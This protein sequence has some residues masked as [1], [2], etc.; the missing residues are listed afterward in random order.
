MPS[1][2]TRATDLEL[3]DDPAITDG[4]L[5]VALDELRL[6]GRFLGGTSVSLDALEPVLPPATPTRVLDLGTGGADF[7]A[8][9]VRW[10]APHNRDV[11]VEGVD[12]NP[13]T[14]ALADAWLDQALSPPIAP[15]SPSRRA[16]R[17]RCRSAISSSTWR[18]R[19]SFS[20]TSRTTRPWTC[21]ARWGAWRAW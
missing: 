9:V 8:A 14:L 10:G 19:R 5:A 11:Q 3:M 17:W 16:T 6:V 7:P 4:R 18:T 21:C 1:F 12:L 15:A 20:T 13:V 2:R